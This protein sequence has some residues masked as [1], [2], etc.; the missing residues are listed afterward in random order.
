MFA[1][2]ATKPLNDKTKGFRYNFFGVKGLVRIRKIKS[3][4][5]KVEQGNCMVKLHLG[6]VTIYRELKANKETSRIIRH[7]AG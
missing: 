7:F 2:F 4:G 3:R 6:K 5:F 1:I